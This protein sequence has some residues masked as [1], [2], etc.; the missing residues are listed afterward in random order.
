MDIEYCIALLRTATL[1]A[2]VAATGVIGPIY[3]AY[4]FGHYVAG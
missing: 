1:A 4:L 3:L 2:A